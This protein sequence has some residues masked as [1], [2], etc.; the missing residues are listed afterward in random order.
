MLNVDDGLRWVGLGWTWFGFFAKVD[1][2]ATQSAARK[3]DRRV[4][5]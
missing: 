2:R 4:N 3:V 5:V 1:P